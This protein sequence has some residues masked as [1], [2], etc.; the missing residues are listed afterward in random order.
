MPTCRN[1]RKSKES[2]QAQTKKNNENIFKAKSMKLEIQPH[3]QAVNEESGKR[4][5][6]REKLKAASQEKTQKSGKNIS[7]TCSE[8]LLKSL[9]NLSKQLLLANKISN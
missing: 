3:G 9:I 4:S 7:R 1:R 5:T 2:E 8:T 6:L